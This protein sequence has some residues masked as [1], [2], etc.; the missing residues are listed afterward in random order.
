MLAWLISGCCRC[1]KLHR[2][3]ANSADMTVTLHSLIC[4][5]YSKRQNTSAVTI[6]LLFISLMRQTAETTQSGTAVVN[7]NNLWRFTCSEM[8]SCDSVTGF[9]CDRQTLC[10]YSSSPVLT[11]TH[12][13]YGKGQI[14]TPYKIRTPERIGTKFGTVDYVLEICPQNKFGDGRISGGFWV[15][16]WNIRSRRHRSQ[17]HDQQMLANM[18]LSTVLANKSVVCSKCWPTKLAVYELVRFLLA[19]KRQTA[20]WLVA[21]SKH[22]GGRMDGCILCWLH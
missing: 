16:M 19:N 5:T 14:L 11:A 13:S 15:N 17:T 8:K 22:H 12:R 6:Y 3:A 7:S 18:C 1:W 21:C 20:L 9:Q 2:G 10:L 4:L